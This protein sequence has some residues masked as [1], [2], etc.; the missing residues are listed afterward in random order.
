MN[1]ASHDSQP[2]PSKRDWTVDLSW[3]YEQRTAFLT[4]LRDE[5]LAAH[6]DYAETIN[7]INLGGDY[8][9]VAL[10]G[11]SINL[12]GTGS[13]ELTAPTTTGPESLNHTFLGDSVVAVSVTTPDGRLSEEGA[14]VVADILLPA[15]HQMDAE[16]R[17]MTA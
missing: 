9:N 17:D 5:L 4:P 2:D 8:A 14:A 12:S 11:L 7:E 15:D 1:R 3:P 16:L 10:V 6:P 13:V